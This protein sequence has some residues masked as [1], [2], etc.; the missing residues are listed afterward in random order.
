MF[1]RTTVPRGKNLQR[2]LLAL[3]L[4]LLTLA[5]GADAWAHNVAEGDKGYIQESSGVLFWPFVYLGAKHMVTGY[6]H[7]LFL[8]GVI[9]FLYRMKDIGLYVTLFAIGHS[10]TMLF[11]V[12]TGI[13]ANAYII[14]AIIGLSVV[15]KALDNLGAYQRWFG[16]QPNTK[17][18]TL[19]FGFFHGFGLATKII[20]FEIAQEGL[21]ANLLAFN[22]G[23]EIGQLL[24][25]G[26]I[27]IVMGFWRRT[28]SF[29]RHAFAANVLLMT[30]GFVL[31]GY[32]LAG[33]VIS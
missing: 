30:A 10:T 6:D 15:Y 26:A 16:V 21:I 5:A 28:P 23:V 18:A 3:S 14:D 17:A 24:A 29:M 33:Y 8:F 32:Q 1:I 25:L 27:L 20:E 22:I 19:I 9:F 11:G 12:L 13:S 31:V 2:L 7:L 4:T